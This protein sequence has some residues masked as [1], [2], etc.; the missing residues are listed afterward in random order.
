MAG[1][2]PRGLCI[3]LC[4]INSTVGDL[5]AN[6]RKIIESIKQAQ[7][8]R[9]DIAVFPELALT[10]AFPDDLLLRRGFIDQNI[11]TLNSIAQQIQSTAAVVGFV[12]VDENGIYNA[13]AFIHN[14]RIIGR[15]RKTCLA[16]VGDFNEAGY[17]ALGCPADGFLLGDIAFRISIG[18][19]DLQNVS[20]EPLIVDICA[21]SFYPG[22]RHVRER[23]LSE[24]ARRSNCTIVQVNAI[25]GQD[26]IVFNG[27]SLVANRSGQV[28]FA[29]P[30]REQIAVI[31]VDFNSSLRTD[32]LASQPVD[33]I[34]EIYRALVLGVGDYARK[35]GFKKA[36]LGMS[37]GLDSALTACVA[38][39]AL[40][41]ENV[42]LLI[43]P[44]LYSSEETQSDAELMADILGA[45]CQRIAINDLFRAYQQ[46]LKD[47]FGDPPLGIVQENLQARIRGNLLMALSNQLG[48]L[49]LN[50]SNKSE[51]LCGYST[52]YGDMAG[53]FAVLKSCTKTM[54]YE[55]CEYRNSI[56][57]VIPESI[58]ARPPSAE[59]RP[60]QKDTDSLPPYDVLDPLLD[61]LVERNLGVDEIAELGFDEELV[62]RIA[63]MVDRSEY[64]RR[65]APPGVRWGRAARPP[66][67]NGYKV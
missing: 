50:T 46:P 8:H 32:A 56:S 65:Q 6:A 64:K 38:V 17:F 14:G 60:D 18:G 20:S 48:L 24:A 23:M 66:M 31:E 9:A 4:Q 57:L 10:G 61:A 59:L 51:L 33:D 16:N 15:R 22:Q 30:F 11:D 52:L 19:D 28:A 5:G 37:G 2:T 29:E 44:S 42:H 67:T 26:E 3:A 53:G 27:H 49:V 25:G 40:G 39:D 12:D 54:V 7:E 13:A 36:A 55:L 62:R 1:S 43:M 47:M 35:N 21:T 58:I 34:E 63:R 41:A 45:K